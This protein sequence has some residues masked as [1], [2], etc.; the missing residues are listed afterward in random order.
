MAIRII[1]PNAPTACRDEIIRE[2]VCWGVSEAE[3][4]EEGELVDE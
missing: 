2:C 1:S 4:E 3:G